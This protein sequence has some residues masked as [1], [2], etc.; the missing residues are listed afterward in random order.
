MKGT[1]CPIPARGEVVGRP[2]D[3]ARQKKKET[4]EMGMKKPLKIIKNHPV[5][6]CKT[7]R[8]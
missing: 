6:R 3:I 2:A 8:F 1:R 7:N 5:M 4:K